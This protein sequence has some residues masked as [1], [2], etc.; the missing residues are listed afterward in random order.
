MAAPDSN[1]I[2]R[3]TRGERE[4]VANGTSQSLIVGVKQND[5]EAWERLVKLYSPLVYYWC[6]QAG[7]R[8]ADIH[9]VFQEVFCRLARKISQFRPMEN[10]SFR[11]WLRTLTRH[12]A[13]DHFRARQHEPE[14]AGGTGA[15]QFLE[16]IAAP[17][18]PVSSDSSLD[19]LSSCDK[20]SYNPS[21]GESVVGKPSSGDSLVGETAM[22]TR[23]QLSLLH[24]ALAN[25]RPH[26]SE[27]TFQ[28]FWMV[29]IEGRETAE[30]AAILGMRPGTIRVSKSRILKRLRMELGD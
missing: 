13:M 25:I 27:A 24:Q 16:Q 12:Q 30:V 17:S 18:V 26:F 6:G 28:A 2:D 8:Q 19:E 10:G 11:G 4:P 14:A 23:L 7:L 1:L 15:Q 3:N 20:L 21:V 9:D 22:E 29:A 5:P